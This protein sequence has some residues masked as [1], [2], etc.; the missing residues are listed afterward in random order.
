MMM[1]DDDRDHERRDQERSRKDQELI[2]LHFT[3]IANVINVCETEE[4]QRQY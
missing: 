3:V 1:N 2:E 4:A